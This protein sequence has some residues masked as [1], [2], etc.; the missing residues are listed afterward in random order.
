MDTY[1][2]NGWALYQ[3]ALM[4]EIFEELEQRVTVLVQRYTE[5]NDDRGMLEDSTIKLYQAIFRNMYTHIPKDPQHPNYLL[6]NTLINTNV[7]KR[8]L[9]SDSKAFLRVK[10]QGLPDRYRLFFRFHSAAPRSIIYIW[11][12]SERT[13]R[14]AGSKT[15]VYTV[16]SKMLN[17]GDVPV[18]YKELLKQSRPMQRPS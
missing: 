2:V 3:H 17:K 18:S 7:L 6:G 12:N 15:D 13:Q 1:T 8:T 11:M 16:F 5:Q 14:K 9:K 10:R 4:A